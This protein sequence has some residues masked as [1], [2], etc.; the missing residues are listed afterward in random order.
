MKR[1]IILLIILIIYFASLVISNNYVEKYVSQKVITAEA[2][3]RNKVYNLFDKVKYV[4][5]E[6]IPDPIRAD[7]ISIPK[8]SDLTIAGKKPYMENK[9]SFFLGNDE[10]D[11]ILQKEFNYEFKHLKSLYNLPCAIDKDGGLLIYTR[12]NF[13]VLQYSNNDIIET[14]YFPYAIGYKVSEDNYAPNKKEILKSAYD[15]YISNE[16]SHLRNY[17]DD[18]SYERILSELFHLPNDYFCIKTK[19]DTF[20]LISTLDKPLMG[21]LEIS[22]LLSDLNFRHFGVLQY[23]DFSVFIGE[24]PYI[25]Y[26]VDRKDPSQY[27]NEV[28]KLKTTYFSILTILFFLFAGPIIYLEIMN[29]KVR[30][31][32]L[33]SKLKR[34]CNPSLYMKDYN[35]DKIDTANAIYKKITETSPDDKETL[36]LLVKEAEEK[37]DISFVDSI[38]VASLKKQ[39]NP[40]RF[41]KPYQPE[42]VSLANELYAILN[43][44][45]VS[46][47]DIIEIE[48]KVE[49]L[50]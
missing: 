15:F 20:K 11:Q 32:S 48:K 33:Y 35:K 3:I 50:Q 44:E 24:A 37:M 40:K 34:L 28:S 6:Y 8:L 46:Y 19:I 25:K 21:C 18:G 30:N 23:N 2:E 26:Y 16:E 31:E 42:K 14:S 1:I 39:V 7:K 38:K 5:P 4:D 27:D 12:W 10:V 22:H 45:K 36:L 43:K 49:K 13:R 47:T 9:D 17:I 41:M 29:R